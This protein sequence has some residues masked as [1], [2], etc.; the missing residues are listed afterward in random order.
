MQA[1]GNGSFA[2]RQG[3]TWK[4]EQAKPMPSY[5]FTVCVG[6]FDIYTE[7][8]T[9]VPV[10]YLAPEGVSD[11]DFKRIFGKTPRMIEFYEERYGHPYPW[12]RYD[13]VVVHDFIFGGMENVAATGRTAL[14]AATGGIVALNVA[15]SCS[16]TRTMQH[17]RNYQ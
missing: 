15:A 9:G 11:A 4:W 10:R 6:A 16:H 17:P 8:S 3:N 14:G 7:E 2:G 1:I 5:L 12:P 13:Q